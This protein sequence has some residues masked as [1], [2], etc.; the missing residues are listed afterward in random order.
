MMVTDVAISDRDNSIFLVTVDN[1]V[2][3]VTLRVNGNEL[4]TPSGR[5]GLR[6]R[7]IEKFK[8]LADRSTEESSLKTAIKSVLG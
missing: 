8:E 3:K 5:T 6:T 4:K 7:F 1:G 2:H